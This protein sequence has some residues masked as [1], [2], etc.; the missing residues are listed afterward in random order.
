MSTS[1]PARFDRASA[2]ADFDVSMAITWA[3][4]GTAS[5]GEHPDAGVG[6]DHDGGRRPARA[7]PCATV[8][9][10]SSAACGPDWKNEPIDTRSV[11]AGDALVQR[12]SRTDERA[13]G[14]PAHQLAG[15]CPTAPRAR[16][17]P[18]SSAAS[19]RRSGASSRAAIARR[20]SGW[21]TRQSGAAIT[22]WEC[23]ARN[24]ARPSGAAATR[25]VVRYPT[26]STL[27]AQPHVGVGDAHRCGAG[28]RPTIARLA[29]RWASCVRCCHP[30][31][32]HPARRD[33][34]GGRTRCGEASTTSTTWAR[35]QSRFCVGDL[36]AHPSRRGARRSRTR[37]GR[38]RH[39]RSPPRR[40][41][42]GRG[43]APRRAS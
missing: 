31:P 42:S 8:S 15:A 32:P 40:R 2:T 37:R 19:A 11:G 9:T 14:Q 18:P 34:H 25:T 23:S 41:R 39:G 4:T 22:S 36:D 7:R 26:G 27:A 17:W 24:P 30:Q 21:A 1:R 10:S 13:V 29:S 3:S 12:R 5:G 33:G 38:R 6:V 28:R 16:R 20:N 43:S 35:A